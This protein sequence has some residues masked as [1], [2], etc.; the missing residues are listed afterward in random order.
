MT[1]IE[2]QT[3]FLQVKKTT[4]SH[5]LKEFKIDEDVLQDMLSFWIRKGKLKK[6]L[7]EGNNCNTRCNSCQLG[8]IS[9]KKTLPIIHIYEWVG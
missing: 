1:L 3:Y 5:L 7:S 2:I 8:C 4:L 6:R 9:L